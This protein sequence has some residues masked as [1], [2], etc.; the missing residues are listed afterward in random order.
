MNFKKNKVI[1]L[2]L[3]QFSAKIKHGI[4]KRKCIA[5]LRKYPSIQNPKKELTLQFM[6]GEEG[7][8]SLII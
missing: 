8:D 6:S 3:L 4:S 7:I 1:S 5:G 2:L